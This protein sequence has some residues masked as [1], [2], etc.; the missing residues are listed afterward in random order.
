[1][2]SKFKKVKVKEVYFAEIKI[3]IYDFIMTKKTISNS[4]EKKNKKIKNPK[5]IAYFVELKTH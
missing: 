2:V 3:K 4:I 1:M 5:S